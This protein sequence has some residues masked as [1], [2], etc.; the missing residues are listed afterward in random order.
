MEDL[1]AGSR[2]HGSVGQGVDHPV[3]RPHLMGPVSHIELVC[4]S[5][6]MNLALFIAHGVWQTHRAS[7]LGM[8]AANIPYGTGM[9]A[10]VRLCSVK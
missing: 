2:V 4:A 6:G 10:S 8:I 3:V 5:T 9:C 7:P 1:R